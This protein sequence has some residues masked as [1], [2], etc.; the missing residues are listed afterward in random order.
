MR[1]DGKILK[2]CRACGAKR[3]YRHGVRS[4]ARFYA[5]SGHTC[6]G[7]LKRAIRPKRS[8][9]R[10]SLQGRAAKLSVHAYTKSREHLS[11]T[12]KHAK[13][14]QKWQAKG[15]YYTKRAAMTDEQVAA[16]KSARDRRAVEKATRRRAIRLAKTE[17]AS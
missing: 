12:S 11:E 4:C 8:T 3:L 9:E 1:R 7:P 14:A 5:M 17:V 16:E 13:L 2:V 10:L 15:D 6:G